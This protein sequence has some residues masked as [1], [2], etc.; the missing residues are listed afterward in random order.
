MKRMTPLD[1]NRLS[2]SIVTLRGRIHSSKQNTRAVGI[3]LLEFLSRVRTKSC[4]SQEIQSYLKLYSVRYMRPLSICGKLSITNN[5]YSHSKKY[6]LWFQVGMKIG[7]ALKTIGKLKVGESNE[8]W[9]K[10][11]KILNSMR[12]SVKLNKV[13]AFKGIIKITSTWTNKYVV[14]GNENYVFH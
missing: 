4:I 6:M 2:R 5:L 1:L 13:I 7:R 9:A 14:K 11:T 12:H 10:C 8:M 3:A